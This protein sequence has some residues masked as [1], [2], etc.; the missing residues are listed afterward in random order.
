MK[1]LRI[2]LKNLNSLK[3][4][5]GVDLTA[6]PLASAGLF[7]ITGPTGAGKSTL[8]DA[9]T[10][11]LYGKAARYG[12]EANPK[13][14]MSRHCGECSAEVEFEVPS[15]TFRAVWERHRA[16]KKADGALQQ[17]KRY[18]YNAAGEPL[19]QSIREA[20]EKIEDLLGL[21]YERFLRSVLLAQGEF[22]RFLKADANER[23]ELLESLTGTAIYSRL[24][25]LAF[26]EANRRENDV[27][28]KEA[29][30]AQI[31]I[32][33][34][35]E[36]RK[37][38][39]DLQR[40]EAERTQLANGIATG[41]EMLGEIARLE[42]A[43]KKENEASDE[44]TQITRD[45]Q[46][47]A[48]S[49]ERLRRHRLTLP[50]AE[51]LA[52]LDAAE[53][54]MERAARQKEQAVK[55]HAKAIKTLHQ[56]NYLLRSAIRG[57]LEG[58]QRRA[59]EAGETVKQ[60]G[61]A[62]ADA[63]AWLDEHK[64]DAAL[65][66][67]L[68]DL[69][70]AIGDLK[71]ARTALADDW[72]DWRSVAAQLLPDD[73]KALPG[74][75]ETTTNRTLETALDAFLGTAAKQQGVLDA[76][77]KDAKQQLD[78]RKDHLEKAKLIARLEDHRHTLK[79]GQP[80]PLCGA[81]E[82]PYAEGAV[83][84]AKVAEL[85]TELKR[86]G[87]KHEQTMEKRRTL[88]GKIK[89][90]T[91]DRGNLSARMR[92]RDD[93]L[94][95]LEQL[96]QPLAEKVPDAGDEDALRNRL[97]GRELA[98]RNQLKAQADAVRLKAEAEQNMKAATE[99]VTQLEKRVGTLEAPPA[100]SEFQPVAV[101]DLPAVADA[102][103]AYS[104]AVLEERTTTTQVHDRTADLEAAV[105]TLNEIKKPLETAVAGIE[106]KTLD[107]LR[108]AKIASYAARQIEALENSLKQRTNAAE[109][110]LGQARKD[111]KTLLEAKV[112][113]GNEAV[114][115][116]G[117]QTAL[118]RDA[119]KLLEFQT[120]RRN[121][122]KADDDNRKLRLEKETE[123]AEE[124]ANLVVWKRLRE[125]I[126][127]HDGSKFRRYAQAISLDILARHANRHLAALSKRYRICRDTTEALDLQIEDLYQ[128]SVRRPT[129]SL[130][131]GESF[132]ASLALALG[133]SDLAGRTV[134]ID[135]LF[136]DEGFGSLDPE[137]LEVA[138]D[139]LESLRQ[140]HKTVG[141]ISHVGLLK[142]RISTQ[143]AVE[144]MAGGVSSIR[145]IPEENVP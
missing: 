21:N 108:S 42:E 141:V 36:R 41:A 47:A 126:G 93:C 52:R 58:Q 76:D 98:Y 142:E 77:V 102:E 35:D 85:E 134:R 29:G 83:P 12:N 145:V 117:R 2:R 10:L 116:K 63:Q 91:A 103:N 89:D 3:G 53:K 105:R 44:Q 6:E 45:T 101:E 24:G 55:S 39:E 48:A 30:L 138:I 95:S 38:D 112:L 135:S 115:F 37:L 27:N 75:L 96:L 14:V 120:T 69:V 133:L 130:S 11:A 127:S 137:T 94:R 57:A 64:S 59:K 31:A 143:I 25:R 56:A 33:G 19:A 70:A 99:E 67:Q 5:H 97:K 13:H 34:A 68:G 111:I 132:L 92:H 28:A 61:K 18:I 79:S 118:K 114:L 66:D 125:L 131:G 124:R 100:E 90:L 80:C 107:N 17:P 140:N 54:V 73:A 128:A 87:E 23:A 62:A 49:L 32:L 9:V 26:E 65:A 86:A 144:K 46:A 71:T 81:L 113:E 51:D 106:F 122:I 60:Q 139:A 40:G 123:L 72:D 129:A 43:R 7:A 88:S 84:G 109:A 16:R 15:G 22:A 78:L 20:E 82:H 74:N 119:E 110:L 1:I 136:I 104:A 50:F 121:R 4:A 8:L